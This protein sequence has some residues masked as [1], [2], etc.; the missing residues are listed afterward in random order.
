MLRVETHDIDKLL[1]NFLYVWKFN[2][3]ITRQFCNK[4]VTYFTKNKCKSFPRAVF[5]PI[6]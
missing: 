1:S 6:Y 3:T 2:L 5:I 4:N